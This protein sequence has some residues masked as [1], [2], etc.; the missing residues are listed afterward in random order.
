MTW[1][2]YIKAVYVNDFIP[3]TDPGQHVTVDP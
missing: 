2:H 3:S 1:T